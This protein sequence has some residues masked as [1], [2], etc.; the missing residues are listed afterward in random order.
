[1]TLEAAKKEIHIQWLKQFRKFYHCFDL[2]VFVCIKDNG[3]GTALFEKERDPFSDQPL[4][5]IDDY[6][7]YSWMEMRP[8]P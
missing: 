3:D 4:Y 1:M 6:Q 2:G 5:R 7:K 8:S